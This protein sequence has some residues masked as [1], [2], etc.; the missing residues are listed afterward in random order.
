MLSS[1]D[2]QH[3]QKPQQSSSNA[4]ASRL[5]GT[6]FSLGDANGGLGNNSTLNNFLL[7]PIPFTPPTLGSLGMGSNTASP[8]GSRGELSGNNEL[9]SMMGW[10]GTNL[11]CP[12]TSSP[13]DN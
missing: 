8:F 6:D 7:A 2:Q 1:Q 11:I 5:L 3:L 13:F 9:S 4:A 12:S 10:A